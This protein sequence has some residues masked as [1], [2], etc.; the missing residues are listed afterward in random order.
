MTSPITLTLE[1]RI[2]GPPEDVFEAWTQPEIMR[3]WLAPGD[4]KVVEATTDVSVGGSFRIRSIAPDGTVHTIDGSYREISPGRR[5]AMTWGYSG[6]IELLCE[7]ETLLEIELEATGD[8]E[9]A[10]T[11]TQTRF[12]TP[13]A[14][15]GYGEGWP[16]CFDKLDRSLL[17]SK[18][19]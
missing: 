2:P 18:P 7:M 4:N 11:L 6:P 15:D 5:L 9:T 1:R 12:T 19:Q 13:E 8:G 3:T 10:M 17:A 14:A 16:S